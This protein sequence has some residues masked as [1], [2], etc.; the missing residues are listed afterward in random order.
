MGTMAGTTSAYHCACADFGLLSPLSLYERHWA[1][2]PVTSRRGTRLR[3][4]GTIW[5]KILKVWPLLVGLMLNAGL[6]SGQL[7]S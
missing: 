6:S 5:V 3:I 4:M 2:E 7:P 1:L